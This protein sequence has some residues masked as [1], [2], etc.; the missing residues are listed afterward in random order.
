MGDRLAALGAP[1][2]VD[3]LLAST[4]GN[5]GRPHV[6][7]ALMEAGHVRH[8]DDAFERFLG[9]GAPAYVPPSRFEA[10]DAI[11]LIH[12]AGGLAVLAHPGV[13]DIDDR[14]GT[15]VE[16]GLDGIETVHPAH[17]EGQR[18]HYRRLADRFGLVSTGGTDFHG[19]NESFRPGTCGV[20]AEALAA[21]ERRWTERQAAAS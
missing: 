11:A 3:R 14:L 17:D 15:L 1:I 7:R 9:R 19:P 5:I 21:L 8:F 20:P 18:R 13:E 4:E 2:D 12:A 6:A 16:M 10:A